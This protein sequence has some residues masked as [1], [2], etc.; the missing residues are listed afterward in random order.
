MS[1]YGR[2]QFRACIAQHLGCDPGAPALFWRGRVEEVNLPTG[3]APRPADVSRVIELLA[4]TGD[5]PR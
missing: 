2:D 3:P 4:A 1:G 5:V